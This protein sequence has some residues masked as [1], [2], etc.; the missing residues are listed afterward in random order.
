MASP[1]PTEPPKAPAVPLTAGF[2][3]LDGRFG[4]VAYAPRTR[5]SPLQTLVVVHGSDFHY[6][7]MCRY[8]AALA[9]ETACVVLAPLFAPSGAVNSD[10]NGF[11]FL[12]S[13]HAEYDRVLLDMVNIVA[14]RLRCARERFFLFG[15]S[16]GAQFAHRF[17]Y[18]HPERLH[19]VSVAAPGMVTLIDPDHP[20]WVG[21]G[22]LGALCGNDLDLGAVRRV[23]VQLLV[24]SDDAQPHVGVAGEDVYNHA[25]G[26][27]VERLRTLAAN[28]RACSVS[29]THQEV[30][31]AEHQFEP[32]AAAAVPFLRERIEALR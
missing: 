22:G 21:T 5:S 7:E 20:A 4:Y 18:V 29:V 19:A 26:N 9:E 25:G 6:E 13:S 14:E 31:G 32:L 10:P 16:G 27:R 24:G 3:R 1:P 2:S 8:F 30:P 15:F 12:R 23:A 11:K 17:L 28:Y